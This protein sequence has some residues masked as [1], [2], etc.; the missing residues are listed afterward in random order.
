MQSAVFWRA[1]QQDGHEL[2]LCPAPAESP[3]PPD[4]FAFPACSAALGAA[5]GVA[6]AGSARGSASQSAASR[7]S[8]RLSLC[9]VMANQRM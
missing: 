5:H 9:P 6:R 4:R 2:G 3:W 8:P 1:A 7:G